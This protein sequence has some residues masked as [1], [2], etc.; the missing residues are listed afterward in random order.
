MKLYGALASPYVCRVVL[1]ARVK[2]IDLPVTA[3]P[4][5]SIKSPEYLALNPLGKMPTLDLEGRALAESTVICE[6]L[7]ETHPGKPLLPEDPVDRAQV[8][9]IARVMD[10]YV[11]AHLGALFRNANPA[12]RNQ[13]DVDAAL[14]ALRKSL[15]DLE[16]FMGPGPFALAD[17]MT[18][19]DCILAPSVFLMTAMLPGF[20]VTNLFEGL[21][22]LARWWSAVQADPVAGPLHQEYL[23]AFQAFMRSRVAG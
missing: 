10:L 8:R 1:T 9:L 23:E 7:D 19:A 18:L 17:R 14:A 13:A 22:R 6:Y 11:L 20:G 21:P 2:G 15:G 16:K 12:Q 4:G 3:P 5:G